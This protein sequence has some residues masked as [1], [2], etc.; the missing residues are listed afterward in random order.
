MKYIKNMKLLFVVSAVLTA[1]VTVI[2]TVSILTEFEADIGYFKHGAILDPI[3]N[4]LLIVAALLF[5][6][7]TIVTKREDHSHSINRDSTAFRFFASFSACTSL[8][9]AYMMWN[10]Y[11]V[12]SEHISVMPART[13]GFMIAVMV[14][15]LLSFAGLM[16]YAFGRND[17]PNKWRS[18][19]ALLPAMMLILRGVEVHFDSS[20]EMNDPIKI[21]L[22]LA[23]VALSLALLYT[24]KTELDTNE[25]SPRARTATLLAAPVFAI[26]FSVA[27]VVSYYTKTYSDLSYL[28]DAVVLIPLCGFVLSSYSAKKTE[29]EVVVPAEAPEASEE[30]PADVTEDATEEDAEVKDEVS[31]PDDTNETNETNENNREDE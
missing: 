9:Y 18:F 24:A 6:L 3:C 26:S 27:I 17:K 31:E 8:F 22:Q 29:D 11:S 19:A 5:F 14:F 13:T 30:A 4:A 10:Q 23:C 7:Q 20:V 21:Q 1:A 12:E 25:T 15:S 2:R 16:V 28:M